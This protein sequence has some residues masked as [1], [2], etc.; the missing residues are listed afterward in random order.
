MTALAKALIKDRNG[1]PLEVQASLEDYAQAT[2]TGANL[3]QHLASKY[4]DADVTHGTVFAQLA[5]SMGVNLNP[6]SLD[7]PKMSELFG[8]GVQAG[9]V[10]S[11]NGQDNSVGARLLM[12]ELI[13]AIQEANLFQNT[14]PL[15]EAIMAKT[16]M[17]TQVSNATYKR[18]IV[19]SDTN[20]DLEHEE[21]GQGATPNTLIRISTSQKSF[22]IPTRAFGLEITK[23]A[24]QNSTLDQVAMMIGSARR[25]IDN[26]NIYRWLSEIVSGSAAK[27]MTALTATNI[28]TRDPAATAGAVTQLAWLKLLTEDQEFNE[29]DTLLSG[30]DSLYNIE[31]RSARPTTSDDT[32]RDGRLDS[33]LNVMNAN[34]RNMDT[35]L[36]G[37]ETVLGGATN[38]LL[39]NSGSGIEYVTDVSAEYEAVE[40][41]VLRKTAEMR[42]DVG[43]EIFRFRDD[44][45]KL[46]TRA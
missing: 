46:I 23:Q 10:T 43:E 42:F 20:K 12:P 11:P 9:S 7:K 32:G 21:I 5:A 2:G 35:I 24:M 18:P 39:M 44:A 8:I 19:D 31:N 33:T 36:V 38:F 3:R 30:I 6:K 14:Q 40:E 28:S 22:D 15:R 27:G 13:I 4:P 45:F 37:D 16:A 1:D 29:Y 41:F 26:K 34:L 17:R 25:S